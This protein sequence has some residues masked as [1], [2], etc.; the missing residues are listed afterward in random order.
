MDREKHPCLSMKVYAR[1]KV[2]SVIPE[3]KSKTKSPFVSVEVTLIDANDNNPTFLPSNLYEFHIPGDARIGHVVGQVRQY[4][5]GH[6]LRECHN[7]RTPSADF[8]SLPQVKTSDPDF[9][10]NGQVSYN[11]Q[12][13]STSNI[14]GKLNSFVVDPTTGIITVNE[15]PLEQGRYALFIE[16][17]DQPENPSERRFSLAVVTIEVLKVGKNDLVPDFLGAPYEFWVGGDVAVGTSVGQVRVTEAVDKTQVIYD[18]LHSYPDGGESA[19]KKI[20]L[21]SNCNAKRLFTRL[22]TLPVPFAVEETSGVI[23]VVNKLHKFD[24]SLYDFEAVV[25]DG[26]EL[27]IV[28][29]LTIHV[30][31]PEEYK[32][33]VIR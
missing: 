26:K 9:G 6:F 21:F 3:Y 33:P 1:E 16:A 18:L 25:T 14:S 8:F 20:L 11:F 4:L 28:T 10:R 15:Y 27:T 22:I 5:K 30:V 13:P 29:N 23:S 7:R 32:Q 19:G 17:A 24:R 12:Y 2:P 31:D